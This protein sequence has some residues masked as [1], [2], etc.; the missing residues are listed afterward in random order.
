MTDSGSHTLSPIERCPNEVLVRIEQQLR[1]MLDPY[2]EATSQMVAFRLTSRRLNSFFTQ[3]AIT[4]LSFFCKI[5]WEKE[6]NPVSY[7]NYAAVTKPLPAPD[8]FV[9]FITSLRIDF[10]RING[11]PANYDPQEVVER[12]SLL[13]DEIGRYTSLSSISMGWGSAW[14]S[15]GKD[16]LYGCLAT[17]LVQVVQQTTAGRPSQL[18][19]TMPLDLHNKVPIH[20]ALQTFTNL[21]MLE[22]YVVMDDAGERDPLNSLLGGVMRHIPLLRSLRFIRT[23]LQGGGTILT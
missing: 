5:N 8:V 15:V 16:V 2:R 21:D 17:R 1:S 18:H 7:R 10:D 12:F 9:P 22:I 14:G 13:W 11:I 23:T 4:H 19:W 3:F 6:R 20:Q